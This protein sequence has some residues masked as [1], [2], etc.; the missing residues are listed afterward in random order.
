[1][2]RRLGWLLTLTAGLL[3]SAAATATTAPW[4]G[5]A[6]ELNVAMEALLA[7]EQLTG[8]AWTL[9]RP[10]EILSGAGGV[11]D[12]ETNLPYDVQTRFHVGSITKT[13]LATGVF[14]LA[15]EGA[16][17]LD[18]PATEYLP[19]DLSATLPAEFAKVSVRHLLDHSS[20]L[21]DAYLWQ[22][23]S[24]KASADSPL[25]AAFPNPRRQLQLRFEPGSRFSYSNMGYTLLGM[26][27][28]QAVGERYETYL[29]KHL[30]QPLGMQDSTFSYTTQSGPTADPNL[31]WGHLDDGSRFPTQPMFLRPA[32]Q[33]TTTAPD[34]ARFAQFLLGDGH[35]HGQPFIDQALLRAMGQQTST[36][37]A[38]QGLGAIYALG[39]ARRDRHGVVGYCHSGSV[40]GFFSRFCLFPEAQ[41]AYAFSINT[42]REQAD[43]SRFDTLLIDALA[44]PEAQEPPSGLLPQDLKKFEGLYIPSPNRFQMF[45]YLDTVFGVVRASVTED[46]MRLVSLQSPARTLRPLGGYLFSADDRLRDSH[47]FYKDATGALSFS[48]GFQNHRK[49]TAAF[50]IAHWLSLAL[51]LT[52]FSWFLLRGVGLLIK[53]RRH[54]F[55]LPEAPA[56]IGCLLVFLPIP[57]FLN[58]SFTVL[59]DLTLASGL[60]ALTTALLPVLT[61]WS[62]WRLKTSGKFSVAKVLNLSAAIA[63]LQW[64]IVLAGYGMLPLRL[65]A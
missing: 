24:E 10:E 5:Q 39:L 9:L 2:T 4:S 36:E 58:Q 25:N 14:R 62:L 49:I 50:V 64:T 8:I 26:V 43:Y 46:S 41:K 29:N 48:T 42:D 54:A 47:V 63:L 44:L 33:F 40:I 27:V 3:I 38:Q 28:E 37:A 22:L 19:P 23:F 21:G 53:H 59:G 52:G 45:A 13:L 31:A 51:G 60:L 1:M 20:G 12:G 18:S 65:W 16:I 35:I 7:E 15:N 11:R 56:F 17:A 61:I 6:P 32:G 55:G 34:L 57:F 30:L